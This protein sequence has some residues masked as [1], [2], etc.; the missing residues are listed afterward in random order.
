MLKKHASAEITQGTLIRMARIGQGMTQE[1]LGNL[2]GLSQRQISDIEG[3][4]G[5]T[6][7]MVYRI[8]KALSQAPGTFMV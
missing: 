5:T 1:E 6:G 4:G 2:V 3:G 7:V 8:E